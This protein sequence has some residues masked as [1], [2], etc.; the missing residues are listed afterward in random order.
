MTGETLEKVD[1]AMALLRQGDR[2]L[3]Q[4]RGAIP[5]IGAAGLIGCFGGKIEEDKDEDELAAACR[6]VAEET[7]AVVNRADG[8]YIGP[9]DVI[10][11][12]KG[13]AVAVHAEVFAFT[14]PE[15][16][17]VEARE[18]EMVRMSEAELRANQDRLTPATR[19]LF[20]TLVPVL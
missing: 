19:K 3:L 16:E 13:E 7:T 8:K 1:I 4:L 11:D 20:E 10:S 18:G 2:Y 5:S 9:V 6:E 14:L 15:D 17:K 12:M